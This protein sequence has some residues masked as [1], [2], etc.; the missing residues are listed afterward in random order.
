MRPPLP[1]AVVSLAGCSGL[2]GIDFDAGSTGGLGGAGAST[3]VS[4]GGGGGAGA[5]GGGPIGGGGAGPCQPVDVGIPVDGGGFQLIVQGIERVEERRFFVVGSTAV[6]ATVATTDPDDSV[7]LDANRPFVLDVEVGEDGTPTTI[8][9]ASFGEVGALPTNTTLVDG[10]LHV[11]GVNPAPIVLDGAYGSLGADPTASPPATGVAIRTSTSVDSN[12]VDTA[13]AVAD[14]GDGSVAVAGSCFGPTLDAPAGQLSLASLPDGQAW[15]CPVFP[16]G[17]PS[18]T[19]EAAPPSPTFITDLAL[20]AGE[21]HYVGQELG[22]QAG[23]VKL[24]RFDSTWSAIPSPDLTAS[25]ALLASPSIAASGDHLYASFPTNAMGSAWEVRRLSPSSAATSLVLAGPSSSTTELTVD[26]S[27]SGVAVAAFVPI[28]NE[29]TLGGWAAPSSS[30]LAARF[31]PT[32][33]IAVGFTTTG[34]ASIAGAVMNG[35]SVVVLGQAVAASDS[36][37]ATTGEP[38]DIPGPSTQRLFLV[39]RCWGL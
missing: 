17:P 39:D 34:D 20:F 4:T 3:A 25:P 27:P 28:P 38:G 14:R 11:V 6:A 22:E 24:G 16:D 8:R 12:V 18:A 29:F 15:A 33:T 19:F 23:V 21:L 35:P 2:F 31:D 32:L 1:F 36:L 5:Q 30:F 7:V 26:A 37:V 9:A 13:R 10:A